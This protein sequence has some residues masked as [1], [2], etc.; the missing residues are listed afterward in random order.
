MREG[1]TPFTDVDSNALVLSALL[2]T[3]LAG[4]LDWDPLIVRAEIEEVLHSTIQLGNWQK[5]QAVKTLRESEAFWEGTSAASSICIALLGGIPDPD[6]LP[7]LSPFQVVIGLAVAGVLAPDKMM[8]IDVREYLAY[9]LKDA[10][11]WLAPS[12]AKD[13]Q[14]YLT[15]PLMRCTDCGD[16]SPL[17]D[18]QEDVCPAC[19][20]L[21]RSTTPF[22]S[23]T[24]ARI[25]KQAKEDGIGTTTTELEMPRIPGLSAM[26]ALQQA[27]TML[28]GGVD[29]SNVNEKDPIAVQAARV[30]ELNAFVSAFLEEATVK[31]EEMGVSYANQGS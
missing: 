20:G 17:Y 24:R 13:L 11:I 23:A 12:I 18:P 16:V 27:Q 22:G 7:V 10:G 4:W 9:C 28:T 19:S 6:I 25:V 3:R 30:E 5:I 31:S 21:Y 8:T 15:R 1:A 26:A 14:P 2:D 29:F